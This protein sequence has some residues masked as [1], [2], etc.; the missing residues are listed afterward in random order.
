M[1]LIVD[2][3]DSSKSHLPN[4]QRLSKSEQSH[5][6]AFITHKL[7]AVRVH[8]WNKRDYVYLQTPWAAKGTTCNLTIEAIARTLVHEARIR[9]LDNA[10]RWPAKLY[11]QMDNTSRDNKNHYV[12]AYLSYLVQKGIFREIDVN[13]LPVGHTHEDIDQLFSVINRR[14]RGHDAFTFPQWKAEVM[15]AF[16]RETEK[17]AVVEYVTAIHDYKAWLEDVSQNAY[18]EY[19]SHAFHFR[20]K[21][22]PTHP[23]SAVSG[24]LVYC[25]HEFEDKVTCRKMIPGIPG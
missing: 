17:V 7:M 20:I 11:M 25:Y 16:S 1:S 23:T 15:A 18:T 21:Q 22:A 12:F 6:E 4:I 9:G 3:S 8:A 13:F 24:Y 19:R 14:L 2:G 5:T 10:S